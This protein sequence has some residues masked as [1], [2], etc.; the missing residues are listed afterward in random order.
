[1][2]IISGEVFS[3]SCPEIT[4]ENEKQ[5]SQIKK[6]QKKK[7]VLTRRKHQNA[8]PSSYEGKASNNLTDDMN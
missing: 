6:D 2:I 3:H 7:K 8:N 5:P 4:L 1:M